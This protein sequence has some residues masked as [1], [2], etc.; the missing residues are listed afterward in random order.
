MTPIIRHLPIK[1]RDCTQSVNMTPDEV[2]AH[3]DERDRQRQRAQ[4]NR[5]VN[6]A[7]VILAAA[8]LYVTYGFFNH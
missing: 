2:T 8:L 4:L 6:V 1:P 7:L 5:V 3:L